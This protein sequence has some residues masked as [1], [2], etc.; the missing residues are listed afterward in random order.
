MHRVLFSILLF[1]LTLVSA[2]AACSLSLEGEPERGYEGISLAGQWDISFPNRETSPLALSEQS[3]RFGER[4]RGKGA[5]PGSLD[6]QGLGDSITVK[7]PWVMQIY[8]SAFY[9]SPDMAPY[10]Q[11]G[12][13]RL[14]FALTPRSHYIGPVTYTRTVTLAPDD[15]THYELFLERPHITTS[16][17][18]NGQTP[19]LPLDGEGGRGKGVSLSTPHI[20]DLGGLLHPGENT[21]SITVNNDWRQVGVGPDSYSVSDNSQGCWNGIVGRILLRPYHRIRRVWVYPDLATRTLRV[22]VALPNDTIEYTE[23]L[24]ML[25]LPLDG[26]GA[27]WD[28]FHPTLHRLRVA[29][30]GDTTYVTYGIRDLQIRDRMFYLNGREIRLRGTVDGAQ[31]PMTGYPSTDVQSWMDA[32]RVY[33]QWGINLVRFHSWCPPEAAFVAA[34]SLGLYLQPEGPTWANH[35]VHLGTGEI[36]DDYLREEAKAILDEYG[37]HPSFLFFAFGNEPIGKWVDWC[38]EHVPLLRQYDPRHAYT[39]FSVNNNWAWQPEVDYVVKGTARGLNDWKH[40]APDSYKTYESVITR[41]NGKDSPNT[42]IT[43]PYIAHEHGQ[44]CVFPD[45][46]RAADYTGAM[47]AGGLEIVRDLLERNHLSERKDAFV[48]ASGALQLL[49]T[50][51]EIERNL[52]TPRFAGFQMLSLTDFMGQGMASVGLLDPFYHEK[53]YCKAKDFRE[54]CSPLVPLA[55]FSKYTY[56]NDETFRATLS[57]SD[58]TDSPTRRKLAWTFGPYSGTGEQVSIPLSFVTE[59]QKLTLTVT[60]PGTDAHNHW[61]IWVYPSSLPEETLQSDIHIISLEDSP[62]APR[63]GKGSGERGLASILRHGGTVL[64]LTAGHIHNDIRQSFLPVFWNTSWFRMQPPHTL[65]LYIDNEH[66]LFRHFPTEEH[67]DMQWWEL[68]NEADAMDLSAFPADF[69]PTVQTI[70]TWWRC[71]KAGM[72][73]ECRVGR[74]RLLVTSMDITSDL[75]HRIVA[76]QMRYALI[77]YM[78]SNDFRPTARLPLRTIRTLF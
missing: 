46:D 48:R 9:T 7:T 62:L 69:Q 47:R 63:R 12:Q 52:R 16:V 55:T 26:E 68:T 20:Y 14:P 77:Q 64:L 67:S 72:L 31:W 2:H 21:I 43:V 78:Q 30:D 32:F 41:Y 54:F 22:R 75:E 3:E 71:R 35:G 34:D 4:G 44:W 76:R 27:L 28:E 70:D 49:C 38:N 24:P 51:A 40:H 59:A 10:R 50:K 29:V 58:Y 61:D 36:L 66:P 37:N 65:S 17:R 73:F 74:G 25:P 6:A 23:P 57:V 13:V 8:D 1:F 19:P 5:L 18:V 11:P 56:A 53:P 15:T 42:P 39:G 45:P 60:I 33:K